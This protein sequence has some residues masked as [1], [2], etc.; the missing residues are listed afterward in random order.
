[1][2]VPAAEELGIKAHLVEQR[3][4]GQR[5]VPVGRE[6]RGAVAG[7]PPHHRPRVGAEALLAR[8]Q[9]PPL[10]PVEGRVEPVEQGRTHP[11]VSRGREQIPLR[12]NGL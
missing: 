9:E 3:G 1:M 7:V 10:H 6:Q 11:Q 2:D 12:R 5:E 8:A 4:D